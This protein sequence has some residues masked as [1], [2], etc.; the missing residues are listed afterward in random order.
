MTAIRKSRLQY[1]HFQ[2][3]TIKT[4]KI[5]YSNDRFGLNEKS[6]QN[7][8]HLPCLLVPH[9]RDYRYICS[10]IAHNPF[11]LIGCMAVGPQFQALAHMAIESQNTGKLH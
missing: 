1:I 9:I 2:C 7:H 3:L 8:R 10:H 11:P 4:T 6:S 5:G